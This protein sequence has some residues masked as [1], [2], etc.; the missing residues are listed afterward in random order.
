MTIKENMAELLKAYSPDEIYALAKQE[1]ERKKKAE[2]E[3]VKKK[4]EAAA[5]EK[6][7]A[8]ARQ[9]VIDAMK[10]YSK[11]MYGVE[12]DVKLMDNFNADLA[13]IEKASKLLTVSD[14]EKLR[15]FLRGIM[16]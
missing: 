11:V 10:E 2:A 15:K 5:K 16:W 9:K 6:E 7:V 4:A 14:D 3:E 8:S 1:Q 12:P 13:S